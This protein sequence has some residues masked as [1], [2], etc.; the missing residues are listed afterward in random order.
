MRIPFSPLRQTTLK[1]PPLPVA[2]CGVRRGERVLQIGIDDP[3]IAG[4]IA[5]IVGVSGRAAFA[6]TGARA[7]AVARKAAE[8]AMALADVEIAALP[9]LPFA[10]ESFDL[11]V[12]NARKAGELDATTL[13]PLLAEAYRVLRDG[14]RIVAM[15]AGT[16]GGLTAWLRPRK[17][18]EPG[19]D[20]AGHL[21]QAGFRAVRVLAD[22]EGYLFSEGL[23]AKG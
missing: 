21:N 12:L 22:R 6:V 17:P 23:R 1:T 19:V 2:M 3:A 10:N 8:N 14:G 16:A 13:P 5:A 15:Q 7:A 4:A 9:R 11:V 20:L 18:A